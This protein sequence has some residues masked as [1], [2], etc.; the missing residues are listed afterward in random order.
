MHLWC[1]INFAV[2]A[3]C[4]SKEGGRLFSI[5]VALRLCRTKL[6]SMS[7]VT[8][9]MLLFL[10]AM[11]DMMHEFIQQSRSKFGHKYLYPSSENGR[12]INS[13]SQVELNITAV[14]TYF[15]L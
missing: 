14:S 3:K 6:R 1:S 11:N 10:E 15:A 8:H 4:F 12:M 7:C 5:H 2:A 9:I 13:A